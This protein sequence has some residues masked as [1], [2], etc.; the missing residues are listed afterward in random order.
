[1][2]KRKRKK[3][4]YISFEIAKLLARAYQL[5]T[6]REWKSLK[7]PKNFPNHPDY[8]YKDQGW[9]D[10]Y[11]FLGKEKSNAKEF[12][13]YEECREYVKK[14]GISS[15]RAFQS[16]KKLPDNIPTHPHTVY[17]GKGWIDWYNFFDKPRPR[18]IDKTQSYS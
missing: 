13:S 10:W 14:N 18:K 3:S 11:D 16:K 8:V 4:K 15:V 5:S 17:M 2:S 7:K 6:S 1:M 9:R 12:L